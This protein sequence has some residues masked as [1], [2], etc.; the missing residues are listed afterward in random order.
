MKKKNIES[1]SIYRGDET[2]FL[3]FFH[4]SPD[5]LFVFDSD[6]FIVE[7]NRT[8][9]EKLQYKPEELL[10]K[11]I[12]LLHSAEMRNDA[13]KYLNE[14]LEGHRRFCPLPL[15]SKSGK[16]LDVETEISK[17]KWNGKDAIFSISKDFT[18]KLQTEEFVRRIEERY[19]IL[20]SNI[21]DGVFVHEFTD[22]GMPGRFL[23]VNDIAC[24][25]LGYTREELLSMSPKDIDAPES[26]TLVPGM[27]KKLEENSH[28]VW[29]GIHV[30][31]KGVKIPVEISNHLFEL[32]GKP[33][34]LSTVRDITDRKRT[35]ELLTRSEE[36]YRK[37]FENVQDI[38]YQSDIYGRIVEISPSIERYSGYKPE[39]LIGI[40]IE[41]LYVN[42]ADRKELLKILS[43]KGEIE[44]YIVNLRAK[45]GK[46]IYVSANIHMLY[47]PDGN[48]VGIEGSLRDVS[49]RIIADE[50]IKAS[51]K[52]LRKQNEEY[53][54][55]NEEL[56]KRNEQI[57]LIN[58][59]LQ[60]AS[61]IFMNI[62]TGLY[63]YHLE[64]I[65]NDR[66]LKL[67]SVNPAAER[68]TGI[69]AKDILNRTID[70]NFPGLRGNW[71]PCRLCKCGQNKNL[72]TI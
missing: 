35:E 25:R 70:E 4:S 6:G 59:E 66:T 38:F 5:L 34:I 72:Q 7:V 36:K 17:G 11:P 50:K 54:L 63:I 22:E 31:K 64:K 15:L 29:E 61:D 41:G 44:D 8:A 67:I 53:I 14:I 21:N 40:N 56:Q 68:L 51:E 60:Q 48:P 47:G 12:S 37:I 30:T 16:L 1:Q 19:R 3:S 32:E 27:M 71:D 55:L 9:A 33:V 28:I 69:A 65:D 10:G 62:R 42:S 52:L 58:K 24:D 13:E 49:E 39:E 57:L 43:L 18:E 26:Y 45:D 2:N 23:E 20:F 46:V